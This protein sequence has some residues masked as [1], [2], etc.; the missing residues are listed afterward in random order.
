MFFTIND[1]FRNGNM[2]NIGYAYSSL[3][4]AIKDPYALGSFPDNHDNPRFLNIIPDVNKFKNSLV[5]NLYA[6]GIP[7]IY[8]GSEQGFNGGNDPYD[9]EPLWTSMN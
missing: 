6:L 7:I 8:Y 2:H 3:H 1:V 4:T 5:F 9:R